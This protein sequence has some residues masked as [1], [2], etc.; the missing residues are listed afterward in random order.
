MS[1]REAKWYV[2]HTYS[3]HENK[4]KAN[5]EKIVE[6]RGMEDVIYEIVVPTEEKVEIKNGKKKT[7]QKKIFPGYVLVKMIMNDESWYVVR[8]TRGVTGF[9][10]PGSKPIPLSDE[11]V[12]NMGIDNK[13]PSIDIEVGENVKVISGPFENFIGEVKGINLERQTLKVLISMFGRETP[14][15]LEFDQVEKL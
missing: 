13:L 4:V 14:V 9:V 12:R 2:V 7:K 6:N 10:G 8:N 1:D 5:I 3:G 15:E 11:E